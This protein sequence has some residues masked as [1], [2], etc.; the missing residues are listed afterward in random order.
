MSHHIL[1]KFLPAIRKLPIDRSITKKDLLNKTFL[2][3][4]S[5]NIKMYYA[6]HNEY[7]NKKA[8]IIIVG[9][10]PGWRQMKI[11]FMQFVKS[12]ASNDSL[13]SCL[14]KSK[15]AA[16][17]AGSMRTNLIAMLDECDL[18]KALNIPTSSDLFE[19]NRDFL[20]TTS[21][22]KYPVFVQDKNYSG[23]QPSIDQSPLLQHYAFQEFPR[24]LAQVSPNALVIPLGKM[25]EKVFY[26]LINDERL[27]NH[28]YLLGFP[29]PSGANGHRIKQFKRQK[30]QLREKVYKWGLKITN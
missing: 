11:A 8:K 14:Y 12:L 4:V 16:G 10:T 23:H 20:H 6:P 9:I 21:I 27:P 29:H 13:E 15:K 2:M 3:E 7:I 24:E 18:P 26:K 28:E 19:K 1:K 30:E 25:V 17:F 22:I 5:E